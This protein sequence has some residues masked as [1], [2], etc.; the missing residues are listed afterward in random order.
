MVLRKHNE[1]EINGIGEYH[2]T[3][4]YPYGCLE[5]CVKPVMRPKGHC[6]NL[7]CRHPPPSNYLSLGASS[8][9]SHTVFKRESQQSLPT[10]HSMGP[11]IIISLYHFYHSVGLGLGRSNMAGIHSV[12]PPVLEVHIPLRIVDEIMSQRLLI[13]YGELTAFV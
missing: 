4:L 8:P 12:N 1:V 13:R 11:E 10:L 5:Y 6:I 7:S 9:T 2:D 3:L